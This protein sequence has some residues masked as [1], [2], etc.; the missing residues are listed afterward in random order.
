M[1]EQPYVSSAG[2]EQIG[3]FLTGASKQPG[4]VVVLTHA[5]PDGDALGSAL[6]LTRALMH[7]GGR[8]QAWLLGPFPHWMDRFVTHAGVATPVVKLSAEGLRVPEVEPAAVA[9]VDTGSFGQ[10]APLDAWL[11]A[12]GADGRAR[13]SRAVIVDHHLHGHAEAAALRLITT[14]AASCTEALE[15]LIDAVLAGRALT[16]DIAEAMYLGLATDTGWL[17]F[18]NTTPAT[19]RLAARLMEAGADHSAI[20]EAVEQQN[21]PTRPL[22]LGLAMSSL[23]MHHGG[24]VGVMTLRDADLRTI[25]AVGEDTGGFAEPVLAVAGVRAVATLT[26]MPTQPDGR[27][28]VKVS[29]RSKPGPQAVDVAAIA[30]TLGGGGHARAAGI[31]LY[32]SLEQARAKIVDIF[33]NQDA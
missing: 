32:Q 17:R 5:K 27:P 8:A 2:A 14:R 3:A 18:S 20:Y 7:A 22:L 1:S 25:G 33:D 26:E 12:P 29:L 24:A 11:K 31:K 6:A 15:P 16:P 13:T 10:I 4:G 9:I 23:T 28:L 19:L 21:R 30:A